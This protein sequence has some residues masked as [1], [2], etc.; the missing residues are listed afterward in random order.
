VATA[1][2]TTPA[3]VQIMEKVVRSRG[4]AS[5]QLPCFALVPLM[6]QLPYAVV[7]PALRN[8][9]LRESA[10]EL[11]QKEDSLTTNPELLAGMRK[12]LLDER[13]EI[14]TAALEVMHAVV[15]DLGAEEPTA[16]NN[17]MYK[18]YL[19]IPTITLR[20]SELLDDTSEPIRVASAVVLQKFCTLEAKY[21]AVFHDASALIQK[22]VGIC[23]SE[24]LN[25]L[26]IACQAC[27]IAI[28]K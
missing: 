12:A 6:P 19:I 9:A 21:Q 17:L 16:L 7:I 22:L 26:K 1:G 4:A 13:P 28:H 5:I 2:V 14:R 10:L 8:A 20:L 27:L 11:L 24:D 18:S 25:E 23:L 3:I 15:E